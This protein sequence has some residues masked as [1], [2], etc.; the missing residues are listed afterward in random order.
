MADT[1]LEAQ[2][3]AT[4]AEILLYQSAMT[5][6]LGNGALMEY[7]LD[8]GQQVQTV[9]RQPVTE[10]EKIIDGLYNRRATLIARCQ[11]G[12]QIVRPGY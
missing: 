12:A 1:F 9:K 3:T 5:A 2:I 10:L 11:G 4:E 6:F 7:R 8:T